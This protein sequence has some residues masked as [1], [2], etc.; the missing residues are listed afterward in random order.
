MGVS[1]AERVATPPQRR[2]TMIIGNERVTAADG[3]TFFVETPARRGEIVAEVPR[4]GAADVDR[5]VKAAAKAFESWRATHWKDRA[6]ALYK[7]ADAIEA[8]TEELART[9][10]TETGNAIRTITRPEIR[11][12]ADTLRYF[13][14]I[15]SEAK[16]ETVPLGEG[17]LSYTL[18]EPYGVVGA[19]VPWNVP[20]TISIWK[21][22][23]ALATGN[24]MVLKP[25][26]DAPLA[27]LELGRICAEH[28][29]PGVLN[30]V[31]GLGEEC[32]AA[33]AE[34]PLVSKLSFTGNTET[35][36]S[37]MRAAAERIVPV[38][39]ELGG[40][41]PQ[42]VFPDA[43]DDK[44][45]D[46]V[47]AA[48]RFTRQGQSCTAG[49][50]LFLHESIADDFLAKLASKL[51][52]IRIGD[53]LDE[54]T[55]MGAI[56]SK[57]Q[58]EKVYGYVDEGTKQRGAKVVTGGLPPSEGPLA[59][60]YFVEPTVIAQ[61]ANDWRIAREEIFGPVM[62]AIP[63]RDEAD[64][65]RMANDTHY[66]L[67]AYVWTRDVGRAIRTAHAL[68]AGF[69]QIGQGGGQLPGQSYGGFKQ[70]G[71]GREVS[72]E[73][74]LESYTQRKSVT[75]NLGY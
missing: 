12:A 62:V 66:G 30:I 69:V 10:S 74:M 36:K 3:R 4:A 60:G 64:A 34:H 14:G 65:I 63:W 38:S 56:V 67:A 19:I 39:L 26:A 13:A 61:V 29:P 47:I 51:S 33:I 17:M 31:T 5:A 9:L 49:S 72:L 22:G 2:E 6:R 32:G 58:F 43:N 41:S 54:A 28:L 57:R 16:G 48:M 1:T 59:Q 7:I 20:I 15:A 37:I 46:G 71:I 55:D 75:V 23:P 35:G 40:K 50:R 45:A 24:T 73:G 44:T 53:P 18:R 70:S 11:G 25:S 21:I 8:R 52:K 68:D 27:V 42:V